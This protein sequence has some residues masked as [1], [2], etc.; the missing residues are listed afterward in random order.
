MQ[1]IRKN[2]GLKLLSL[3]L[4]IV[5]W[6]YFRYAS[7]P[8][9]AARF[10]QQLS[11]PIVA[12]NLPAGYVARYT[13]KEAVVTVDTRRAGPAVKPDEIKAVLDLSGKGAGVYNVPVELVAPNVVVQSLSPASVSL[14]VEK[15]DQR[16]FALS[17]HYSGAPQTHVVVNSSQLTPAQVV[18]QGPQ[19]QLSQV[20]S[21]RVDVP[22][23]Q[24]PQAIDEMVRPIPVDASGSEVAEL[25]VSPDL[26]RVRVDFVQGASERNP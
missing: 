18:V 7:N 4:A 5:G 22:I 1:I 17:F 6:A 3:A 14:T 13:D 26:I 20:S 12:A 9:L 21:I 11:V 16:S 15:I 24:T 8:V 2:F 10:D 23:P 19:D 25:N